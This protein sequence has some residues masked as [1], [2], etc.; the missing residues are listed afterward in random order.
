MA[1]LP[2]TPAG[3]VEFSTT[4]DVVPVCDVW[5]KGVWGQ[6]GWTEVVPQSDVCGDRGRHLRG[7]GAGGVELWR[8]RASADRPVFVFFALVALSLLVGLHWSEYSF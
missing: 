3:Q 7:H 6:F 1:V 2:A 4:A 5:F 8:I